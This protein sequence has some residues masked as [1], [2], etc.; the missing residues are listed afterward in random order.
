MTVCHRLRLPSAAARVPNGETGAHCVA[1]CAKVSRVVWCA[2]GSLP[3]GAWRGKGDGISASD[4]PLASR[5]AVATPAPG[6]FGTGWVAGS[7][8]AGLGEA[9][10]F[11]F[12]CASRPRLFRW[13]T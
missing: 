13:A 1:L 5:P 9:L 12:F 11:F 7:Q 4:G 6:E 2:A 10:R 3:G 8:E